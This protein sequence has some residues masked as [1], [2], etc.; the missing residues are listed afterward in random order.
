MIL[1]DAN[2]FLAYDNEDDVH[3]K[4]ARAIFQQIEQGD[5]GQALTTDYVFNEVVG[6]ASRKKGKE[7]ALLL[8]EQILRCFFMINVD[9]HLLKEAWKFLKETRLSLNL[10]NCTN[11]MVMR[12]VPISH[13]ATFDQEFL[14]LGMITV[15]D[16]TINRN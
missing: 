5:F 10:V 8:G 15:V 11:V 12:T 3:H 9:E 14:K 2:I 13:I 4:K 1:I 6:V 16:N 7:R